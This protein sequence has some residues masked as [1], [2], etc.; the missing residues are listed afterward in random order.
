MMTVSVLLQY[1]KQLQTDVESFSEMRIKERCYGL[2]KICT[3]REAGQPYVSIRGNL[4][5]ISEGMTQG[6][7]AKAESSLASLD[8]NDQHSVVFTIRQLKE[9]MIHK[10]QEMKHD[11]AGV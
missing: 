11:S 9:L 1:P 2:H 5:K 8:M 3:R 4:T 10:A 6:P 7:K